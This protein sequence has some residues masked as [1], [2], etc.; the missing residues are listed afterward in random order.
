MFIIDNAVNN[1]TL[2]HYCQ[3]IRK[4]YNEKKKGKTIEELEWPDR[5]MTIE[6]TDKLV[7]LVKNVLESNLKVKLTCSECELCSWP[8]G[9]HSPLH[10]HDYQLYDVDDKLRIPTDYNSILYLNNNFSGGEFITG[11]KAVYGK[12]VE[13]VRDEGITIT[14]KKG[15]LTFFNG[16]ST[17]HGLNK[18]IGNT[19]HTAI[20]WWTNTKFY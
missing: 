4:F 17:P 19:R 14:P 12:P 1:N 18:V 15:R 13:S 10:V 3:I 16:M 11:E 5:N 6:V 9:E 8:K 20:F 2:D 7:T